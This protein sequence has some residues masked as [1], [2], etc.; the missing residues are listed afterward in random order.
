MPPAPTA[1]P[2]PQ[3]AAE[4]SPEDAI[5]AELAAYY[6]R[7]EADRRARGLM[8][9]DSGADQMALSVGR[10]TDIYVEIALRDEYLRTARGFIARS[11]AAPLRRW[12]EP[13]RLRLEFGASMSA[14]KRA[15]DRSEVASLVNRISSITRHPM[16]LLP[17]GGNDGANFHILVLSETER[18]AIAPRLRALIPG[19]DPAALSLVTD[20]P[21]ETFCLVLAF[22]RQDDD[23]YS[24]A[25]AIIRAEHPDLTR[26]A[27]YHEEIAQGLGLANDSVLAR[28]S[29]FNDNEEYAFLTALDTLLLRIHYDPRL[30]PGMSEAEAR[31]IVQRISTELI[32]GES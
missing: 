31:P 24:D 27:C 17:P 12:E 32:G 5:S 13:V 18:R 20:M 25:V 2:A 21:R 1:S 10:L 30:Q 29:V 8:R 11:T 3:P 28:P 23:A 22:S 26:L 14:A 15:N 16:R 4:A 6:R 19:I 7:I 9:T